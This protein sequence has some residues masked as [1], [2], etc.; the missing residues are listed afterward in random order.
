MVLS[1][2][3]GLAAAS[4][5]MVHSAPITTWMSGTPSFQNKLG[6]S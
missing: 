3:T 1:P 5:F 4:A 2:W 6:I